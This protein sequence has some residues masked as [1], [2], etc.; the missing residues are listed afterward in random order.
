MPRDIRTI[1]DELV[2][3]RAEARVLIRDGLHFT[4]EFDALLTSY[5]VKRAEQARIITQ[6]GENINLEALK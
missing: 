5:R 2:I 4:P 6:S 3:L 1:E